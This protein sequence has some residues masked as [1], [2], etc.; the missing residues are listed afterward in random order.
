MIDSHQTK[1]NHEHRF[2]WSWLRALW[3]AYFLGVAAV[4]G[5]G[6][7]PMPQEPPRVEFLGLALTVAATLIGAF[8]LVSRYR[9]FH[10]GV[11][12]FLPLAA[13]Y[14]NDHI[15]EL[16][17]LLQPT[18]LE[19]MTLYSLGWIFLSLLP[20]RVWRMF[21][22]SAREYQPMMQSNGR[23]GIPF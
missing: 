17:M 8:F 3:C 10:L 6:L 23:K 15:E 14:L 16:K 1:D 22:R 4:I 11:L 21:S 5:S 12:A 19:K 18:L 9:L 13:I 20:P 7:G 2:Q